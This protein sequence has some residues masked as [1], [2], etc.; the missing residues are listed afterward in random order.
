MVEQ[1]SGWELFRKQTSGLPLAKM[2]LVCTDQLGITHPAAVSRAI[3]D[4]VKIRN[5]DGKVTYHPKV[6]L[7]H[8]KNNRP[9]RFLLASAN[10]SYS[11]FTG[12]IEA[13][14]LGEDSTGLKTLHNWFNNLFQNKSEEFTVERLR[15]MEIKWRA[16]AAN[17]TRARLNVRR[18]LAALPGLPPSV[19]TED[20]DALEDVFATVQLPIGLLNMDYAGNN[21][22]N[23]ER[24]REVLADWTNVR[25]LRKPAHSKQRS[26]LKLLGFVREGELTELGRA[27]AAAG[28]REEVARLWCAWLQRTPNHE[29]YLINEKLLVAKRV[30]AQFW[31]LQPDVRDYFLRGVENPID[32]L[33][34]QTIE[35]LCNARS[36]VEDLS[37]E[38]IKTLAPLVEN[39]ERLPEFVRHSF[40]EYKE[41]KG[42][43]SWN[44][45][46]R[47]IVPL[48]WKE[49]AFEG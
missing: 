3:A 48:A 2:R 8:D 11:A 44:S 9:T 12:S 40:A 41:N 32:R 38:D 31:K 27:A 46:D 14:I 20:L 19:E 18:E 25:V 36:V 17:R 47:K 10:L 4:G 21:I 6:Y 5:F 45:P 34:L 49:A 1:M 30:F 29:L 13:G 7:A 24:V 33:T 28:S 37:I 42:T 16:T 39:L 23:V 15:E 26:E 43:R 22:R 35:L